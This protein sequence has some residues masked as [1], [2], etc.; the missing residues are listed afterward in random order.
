MYASV[1]N[2]FIAF[3]E[4]IED[5]IPYMYLDIKGLVTIG[6][7]NLIDVEKAGDT[8]QLDEVLR[9]LVKMPFVYKQLPNVKNPGGKAKPDE[10]KAEWKL[11][12]NN[13]KLAK[14]GAAACVAGSG[15]PRWGGV[16]A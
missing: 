2:Y 16:T 13:E 5:R 4:P 12:K 9:Q 15:L 8:Q 11:V 3:N 7:G 14:R 6:V 1:K 10:I